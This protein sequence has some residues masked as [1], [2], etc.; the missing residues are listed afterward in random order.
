MAFFLALSVS[1]RNVQLFHPPAVPTTRQKL[2]LNATTRRD[3]NGTIV[4]VVGIGQ[5]I[6]DVRAKRDAEMRQ[7]E[8]E[9]AQAAQSTVSAHVYHEIRNVVGATLALAERTSE[10]VDL[11][12]LEVTGLVLARVLSFLNI[13]FLSC[14]AGHLLGREAAAFDC[15]NTDG[16]SVQ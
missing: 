6:T 13:A 15:P 4:G 14:A 16:A 5:N 3:A 2:L 10:A 9:A 7:R 8:A 1:L 12:L 11:A